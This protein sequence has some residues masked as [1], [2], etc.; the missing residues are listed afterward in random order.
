MSVSVPID[1]NCMD[2]KN[3]WKSK[4]TKTFLKNIFGK[5]KKKFIQVWNDMRVNIF[6]FHFWIIPLIFVIKVLI[7]W[8][9]IQL[10]QNLKSGKK[11]GSK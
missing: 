2:K 4:G 1:F 9:V 6:F 11:G 5:K 7:Y 3:Q 10:K 8:L